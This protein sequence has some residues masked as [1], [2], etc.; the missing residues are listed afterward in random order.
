MVRLHLEAAG[1]RVTIAS[2][3]ASGLE[4]LAREKLDLIVLDIM[5]PGISG[6]DICRRVAR[7]AERPMILILS[8]R[9]AE[10]DRVLGLQEG[11]DDYL[12]KPFSVLEL[13]ARV[14]ALFRR[15]P[16]RSESWQ[17]HGDS[18]RVSAGALSVDRR[19]RCAWF[20]GTKIDLTTREFDLL[21]WFT[22]NPGCVYTRAELLDGVWGKGYDGFEH[23][24]N[25]HLNRLRAK[26]EPDPARP[27]LL[28]TVRGA[29]YKLV[30]PD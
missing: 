13:V 29:G 22:R 12:T 17:Q 18:Q 7:E 5:L 23:T 20:H 9:S 11:A 2:D 28:I 24:V 3:G 16:A 6:L 10:L 1:Y 4:V 30:I 15:P 25:S 14:R 21:L 8:S 26:L 19:E 27:E